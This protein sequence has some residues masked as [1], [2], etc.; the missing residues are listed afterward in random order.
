MPIFK[1]GAFFFISE[2]KIETKVFLT[3]SLSIRSFSKGLLLAVII[4]NNVENEIMMVKTVT[5]NFL[6]L[7]SF[8]SIELLASFTFTVYK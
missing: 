5:I 3:N 7:I 1:F 2:S 6:E 4:Q 8:G